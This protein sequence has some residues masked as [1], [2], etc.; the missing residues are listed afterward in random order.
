MPPVCSICI[1]NYNGEDLLPDC[2]ESVFSQKCEFS[3][4]VIVHDDCSS[5]RSLALLKDYPRVKTIASTENVGFCIA[6]NRM[7]ELARG[8]YLLLLNNDAA[9]KPDALRELV[10]AIT[11]LRRPAILT[12]PQFDWE[13]GALV[14]RGCFLDQF[15]NPVPNVDS[16]RT[17]VAMT[18]GACLFI[19]RNFWQELGGFPTWMDS[20]GEDMFL[21]SL[22]RLRGADVRVH[23]RSGYLHRQG[24]S[25]G[26]N[27]TRSGKLV[28]TFR[29]R[30]LSERNKTAVMILCTPTWLVWP[31]LT[32]HLFCL[33]I[34]GIVLAFL[35]RDACI[36]R[37]I[38]MPVY[39]ETRAKWKFL[40]GL[41]HDIQSRRTV[42]LKKYA[43]GFLFTFRKFSLLRQS[44]IP[45]IN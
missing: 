27:R 8:E 45:T 1:A 10:S 42:S 11:E 44:G 36:W 28:S 33:G 40:R 31:L 23:S 6:N 2:L 20:I 37:K 16:S 43:Q 26:G 41:R 35:K 29:R 18:I 25:F 7:A 15:Y 4:E 12:L 24:A 22:A 30:R 34:E 13:T 14:D 32:L 5:D 19:P 17:D 21:C 38:Y 39:S 9:L 3:F